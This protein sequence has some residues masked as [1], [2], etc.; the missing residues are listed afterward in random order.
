MPVHTLSAYT[1]ALTKVCASWALLQAVDDRGFLHAR[2]RSAKS[3]SPL[4]L[5]TLQLVEGNVRGVLPELRDRAWAKVLDA[6]DVMVALAV[7]LK[8]LRPLRLI[9][10][11]AR[12]LN[13]LQL[14]EFNG[15]VLGFFIFEWRR[16]KKNWSSR[17]GL[18]IGIIRCLAVKDG[19][20]D[21]GCFVSVWYVQ[22]GGSID[23]CSGF[24]LC[25]SRALLVASLPLPPRRLHEVLRRLPKKKLTQHGM[26]THKGRL[27]SGRAKRTLS[28]KGTCV[29]FAFS[30]VD[31]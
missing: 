17:L 22:S 12:S 1:F 21:G 16:R 2:Y 18:C 20:V 8:L 29:L 26:I 4:R 10:S 9:F 23:T 5:W 15:V 7:L 30:L 3:Q 27:K 28:R 25:R 19:V 6:E 24:I 11:Q 14:R 31:I 13:R